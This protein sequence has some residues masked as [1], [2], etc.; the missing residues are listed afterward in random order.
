MNDANTRPVFD[1]TTQDIGNIVEF[2]HVNVRVPDQP[3]AI[4]FY[5]MGLVVVSGI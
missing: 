2:G 4:V 5:I 3:C 1:R